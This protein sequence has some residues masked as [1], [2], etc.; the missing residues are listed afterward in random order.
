MLGQDMRARNDVAGRL[1]ADVAHGAAVA[2]RPGRCAVSR[3]GRQFTSGTVSEVGLEVR[4]GRGG[5][6][7]LAL[8]QGPLLLG[9]VD[10]AQI[11]NARILLRGR[12]GAHEVGNGDRGQQT[13]NRDNDHDF[14]EG[15]TCL[16]IDFVFH[17]LIYALYSGVNSAEGG[18]FIM[19]F[20][21][22]IAF[23]EPHV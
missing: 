10:Q 12:A 2:G 8:F 7:A 23:G 5:G 17:M 4:A 11:V 19:T 6:A 16:A 13:D 3:A 1:G 9:R 14:D 18:L 21:S 20:C 22:L 15:E